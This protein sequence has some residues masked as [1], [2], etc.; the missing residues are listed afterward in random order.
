[1]TEILLQLISVIQ[2]QS[3]GVPFGVS[4][5]FATKDANYSSNGIWD[6]KNTQE[7]ILEIPFGRAAGVFMVKAGGDTQTCV[8]TLGGLS[9]AQVRWLASGSSKNQLTSNGEMPGLKW[10]SVVP[11]DDLDGIAEWSD[12]HSSCPA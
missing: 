9:M 7:E 4:P 11:N 1:M 8:E 5:A 10:N 3:W 2:S 6:C 12:L